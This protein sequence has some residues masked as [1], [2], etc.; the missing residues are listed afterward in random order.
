MFPFDDFI[1]GMTILNIRRMIL[2][3]TSNRRSHNQLIRVEYKH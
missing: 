2:L 1:M 3:H